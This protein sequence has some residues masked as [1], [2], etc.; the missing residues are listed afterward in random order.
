VQFGVA[1]STV[2][3]INKNTGTILKAWEEHCSHERKRNYKELIMRI[4]ML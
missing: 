3:N 1:K 2:E 4:L